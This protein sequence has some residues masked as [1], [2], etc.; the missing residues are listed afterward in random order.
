[1][2]KKTLVL[3]SLAFIGQ[4]EWLTDTKENKKK[5]KARSL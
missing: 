3:R 1:M 2:L 5:L 4:A